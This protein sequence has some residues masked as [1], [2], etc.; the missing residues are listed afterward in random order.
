LSA[1][2]AKSAQAAP[3]VSVGQAS[4]AAVAVA[5]VP[6]EHALDLL[7][8]AEDAPVDHHREHERP[9]LH[10]MTKCDS[11]KRCA[12]DLFALPVCVRLAMLIATA[13]TPSARSQH[14]PLAL[15]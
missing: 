7:F 10:V 4:T 2:A 9:R 6:S 13:V 14:A 15:L 3:L 5:E 8:T 1:E 12:G 11:T